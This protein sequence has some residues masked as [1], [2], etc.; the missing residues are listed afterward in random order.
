MSHRPIYMDHSAT[1]PVRPEVVASMLPYWTEFYGNPSSTHQMGR[2]A[3]RGLEGARDRI[4]QL[5]N[6]EA[7]AIAFTGCGSE[8]DNLALR[9]VMLAARQQQRGNHLIVSR[10]EH[11]AVLGT[12]KQLRDLFGFDL[13]ILD[14]DAF[15]QIDLDELAAA[16]RP[17]T[18]LVSIMA[19]NNEIGT[20][21]PIEEIGR[22]TQA[23]GALFHTDAVQAGGFTAWDMATMP[24][25]LVS[26]APHKLGG[27]KGFGIL[28]VRPGVE[29]V[30]VLTGGSQESGRRAG[31]SDVAGAVGAA[32]A[33]ELAMS[34]LSEHN[35]HCQALRDQL[36]GGILDAVP[37]GA[38]LT[39]HP[40]ARL[41]HH[42]SFA[43][44][45]V[46]GND[47]I[48]NLDQAGIGASSGSACASGN[49][50]PSA[51]L[52]A[53]GLDNSWTLGGLRL[54]VGETNTAADAAYVIE[55][56]AAAVQRLRAFNLATAG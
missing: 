32:K 19:A 7:N 38:C 29:L 27:P 21:Q 3:L 54:T 50:E 23:H 46:N 48:I 5:L 55:K 40:T 18:V 10:L 30:S 33:L 31:T 1:T 44:Q 13:T 43:F 16:L 36:I 39:G 34:G 28:Y 6:T 25:D 11:E 15:G 2:S 52:A 41:P 26:L 4:A 56:T 20:T 22:L 9:G 37:E 42:A 24:L 14:V 12:A 35:A 49:P 8:S 45:H 17:D 53:L 47:L 51:T